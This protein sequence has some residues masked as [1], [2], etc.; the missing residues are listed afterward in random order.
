MDNPIS[1]NY[2]KICRLLNGCSQE[3]RFAFGPAWP[4]SVEISTN[5]PIVTRFSA[6]V[7][8]DGLSPL[9]F[10]LSEFLI[11]SY[12][13]DRIWRTRGNYQAW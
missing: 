13:L 6:V 5:Q 9:Q 3:L 11:D 4:P 2:C 8:L 1:S 7:L 12:C 10:H